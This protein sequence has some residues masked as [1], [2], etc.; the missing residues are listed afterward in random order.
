MRTLFFFALF[1]LF[2][3][4]IYA[5]DVEVSEFFQ[6][7]VGDDVGKEWI[8]L[9]N[10]STHDLQLDGWSVA[11]V[12]GT[13]HTFS[14]HGLSISAGEYLILP[15]TQTSITLN[16]DADQIKLTDSA[17]QTFLSG[18]SG[19]VHEGMSFANISGVWKET[20]PTP[21]DANEL[22]PGPT[23]SPTPTPF[24]SPSPSPSDENTQ[25]LIYLDLSEFSAC[26]AGEEWVEIFN[27][28]DQVVDLSKWS[29]GDSS[30]HAE[31]LSGLLDAHAYLIKS[32]SQ[33]F[34]NNAGDSVR[35]LYQNE[36]MDSFTYT[37]CTS[38]K[39]WIKKG[40][41]GLVQTSQNTKGVQNSDGAIGEVL[42]AT[43]SALSSAQV[44][45]KLSLKYAQPFPQKTLSTQQYIYTP[46]LSN[47]E[48]VVFIDKEKPRVH[49]LRNTSTPIS[50][51]LS[52]LFYFF[53]G[54]CFFIAAGTKLAWYNARA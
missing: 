28:N 54:G 42:S 32:W 52:A 14:L 37:Q 24:L 19:A 29:I 30:G 8:E 5:I 2:S 3:H 18:K 46:S 43:S 44:G 51:L 6:N 7:P 31:L 10:V 17:G 9:H 13:T 26:S 50:F 1:F 23:P 45:Q 35:L 11:D 41:G 39:T 4:T 36:A 49:Y 53:G 48:E 25:P 27:P 20:S 12:Y 21:G 22:S 47:N 33:P 38:G 16:N 40:D 15:Q 34:L